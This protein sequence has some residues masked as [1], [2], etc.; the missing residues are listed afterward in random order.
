MR[1]MEVD[2]PPGRIRASQRESWEGVRT[3]RHVREKFLFWN[4]FDDDDD[5]R[6]AKAFSRRWMCSMKAPWRART[7]MVRVCCGIVI[8][9]VIAVSAFLFLVGFVCWFG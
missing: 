6:E 8:V 3:S 7:P 1:E 5:W 9:I 4:G 2:S